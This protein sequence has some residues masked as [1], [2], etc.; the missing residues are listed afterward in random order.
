MSGQALGRPPP[1][2]PV[3]LWQTHKTCSSHLPQVGVPIF[4]PS[5]RRG[6]PR[7]PPRVFPLQ[8]P[9]PSVPGALP[10]PCTHPPATLPP[11]DF[12]T[13]GDVPLEGAPKEVGAPAQV[14]KGGR[15]QPLPTGLERKLHSHQTESQDK[16]QTQVVFPILALVVI[17]ALALICMLAWRQR[18]GS[19]LSRLQQ[20]WTTVPCPWA[21]E[22]IL[23]GVI[24]D[25]A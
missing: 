7:K 20:V 6:A 17:L 16:S 14:N 13:T 10:S 15:A 9:S 25:L 19:P 11:M 22:G 24:S 23:C 18:R 8:T 21:R 12:P 1:T 2:C 5:Y 4:I 3:S